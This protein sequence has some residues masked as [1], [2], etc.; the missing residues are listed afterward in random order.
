MLNSSKKLEDSAQNTAA[1]IISN[2]A[3][4][5]DWIAETSHELRLPLANIRLLIETLLSGALDDEQTARKMLTTAHSE[6][7]RLQSLL[8]NLLSVEQLVNTRYELPRQWLSLEIRAKYAVESTA[9]M[10]AEAAVEVQLDIA[11]DFKIYANAAQ[12]DQVLLNLLE[13][14][15]KFTPTGGTIKIVSEKKQGCFSVIDTGIGMPASEIP[16]IFQRFYRIE[17]SKS[18]GSTGPGII[19]CQTYTRRT[20]C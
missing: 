14:A 10:A 16:K 13:N 5:A 7:I 15:I 19:H 4:D 11:S 20:W 1:T 8:T 12:L 18:K 9:I 17:R 3:V 2:R 6:V